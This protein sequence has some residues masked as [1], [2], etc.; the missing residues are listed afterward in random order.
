MWRRPSS[1]SPRRTKPPAILRR[2]TGATLPPLCARLPLLGAC[3]V[4]ARKPGGAAMAATDD[5]GC[6]DRRDLLCGGGAALLSAMLAALLGDAKPAR[7]APIFSPVPEVDRVMVSVVVD[8]YQF[9]V[10]A[11]A[12]VANVNAGASA[13]GLSDKPPTR[14]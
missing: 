2:S 12:K 6:V 11:N 7:A 1:R 4:Q 5:E 10:A 14:P 13:G 3:L 9:A 8:N